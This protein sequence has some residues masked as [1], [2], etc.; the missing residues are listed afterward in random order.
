MRD[1]PLHYE[2]TYCGLDPGYGSLLFSL[3]TGG[4]LLTSSLDID[5]IRP[6]RDVRL[7][8]LELEQYSY[9]HFI[10]IIRILTS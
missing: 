4:H 8:F 9:A 10:M 5:L 2:V 6:Q 7:L 3:H 1:K